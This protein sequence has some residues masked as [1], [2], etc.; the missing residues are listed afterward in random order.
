MILMFD[1]NQVKLTSCC[2]CSLYSIVELKRFIDKK[3][4]RLTDKTIR[5][6]GGAAGNYVIFDWNHQK[7]FDVDPGNEY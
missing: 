1:A 2:L 5:T 6:D 3:L 7:S 4:K